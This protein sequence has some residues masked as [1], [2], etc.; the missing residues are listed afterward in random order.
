MKL[1]KCLNILMNKNLQIA[2]RLGCAILVSVNA[3][4]VVRIVESVLALATQMNKKPL[5]QPWSEEG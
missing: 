2:F 1:K 5:Y 4:S 3:T